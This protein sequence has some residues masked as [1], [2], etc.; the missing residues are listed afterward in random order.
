PWLR[1]RVLQIDRAGLAALVVLELV[2]QALLLIERAHP[3]G[4]HGRHVDESVVAASFIGD[5]TVA[6]GVVEKFH[7]ADWH[8]Y[9]LLWL[10]KPKGGF[11]VLRE[12]RKKEIG[13]AKRR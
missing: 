3:G 7:C 2:R 8:I 10:R 11:R 13:A 4:L 6:L 12:A 1:L 9:F 5:E